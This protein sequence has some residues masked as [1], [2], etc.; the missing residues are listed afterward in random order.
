[1]P[2]VLA[3]ALVL[4]ALISPFSSR[5]TPSQVPVA[6]SHAQVQVAYSYIPMFDTEAGA[7]RQCP[8]DAVVW[9]NTRSG[10]YHLKGERW[11]GNT[12]HGAYVCQKEA[13]LAGYRETRN[14]Q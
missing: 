4:L 2:R 5:A 1:M 8:K 12:E 14:G 3:L 11:Y 7:Q 10:V 13:N 9:L 6:V